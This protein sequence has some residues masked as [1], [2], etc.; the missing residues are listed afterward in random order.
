MD[1]NQNEEFVDVTPEVQQP[2]QQPIPNGMQQQVQPQMQQPMP[3]EVQQPV[4]VQPKKNKLPIIIG[5][6]IAV[7][8]ITLGVCGFLYFTNT[9]KLVLSKN[10]TKLYNNLSKN[11]E[12]NN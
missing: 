4:N 5:A 7:L 1:N 3:N 11:A 6:I 9:P 10:L 2:V 8:V 12:S